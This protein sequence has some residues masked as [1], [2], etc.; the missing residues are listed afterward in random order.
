MNRFSLKPRSG[1]AANAND[2]GA[3]PRGGVRFLAVGA[4]SA[5]LA[6]GVA[7]CGG[8]SDDSGSSDSGGSSIDLVGY[9][10]PEET[11]TDAL[12]P[13][14]Q[15]TPDGDGVE[16]SNSFGASGDQSRAV[17]AGQPADVVHFAL[18]PDMTRLVDDGM[19]ADDWDQNEY[20]GIVENSVVVFVVRKG[21]PEGIQSW[22]DLTTG[23]VEVLTPNPFTS[24][25]ARWNLMAA[26][27]NKVLT[28]GASPEEGLQY[29][30]D[31][32]ANVPVQDESARDA[33]GTFLGGK[34]DVLLSYENDAIAA[35]EAG[36][37]IEYVVPDSTIQIETPL[38]A[39]TDAD[40]SAQAFV[41][42]EY[43]DEAQQLWADNG[44][45]PVVQSVFDKN[46]DKFPIP[47]DLFTIDDLGGWDKVS[48]DFFDPENGSVAKIEQ[49][50][51]V[52]TE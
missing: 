24:G 43:T 21:N 5:V 48:T 33:L 14:F 45:R 32:L 28:E 3:R 13:G 44:Y 29:L 15:A 16:F 30:S 39:T 40:D 20:N 25:G 10:T 31:L 22:D 51:G 50:L 41:D 17:E 35:Q 26:Y 2:A 42:Y 49:D 19:V 46:K 47:P 12:E 36:E 8:S 4:L 23:D 52:A 38:A 34:G 1:G 6:F 11:Y 7:A 18:E 9:S 37:D 27:G